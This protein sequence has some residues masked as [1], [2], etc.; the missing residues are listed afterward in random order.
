[1]N[2][3]DYDQNYPATYVQVVV[4]RKERIYIINPLFVS[5]VAKTYIQ[6]KIQI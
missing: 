3:Q 4:K 6:V 2:F 5:F 1:M